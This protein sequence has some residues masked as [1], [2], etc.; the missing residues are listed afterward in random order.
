MLKNELDRQ[1]AGTNS[2]VSAALQH[3]IAL[4]GTSVIWEDSVARGTRAPQESSVIWGDS[5]VWGTTDRTSAEKTRAAI[6]AEKR[7]CFA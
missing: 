2:T 4:N 3:A 6:N 7:E 5:V 1:D